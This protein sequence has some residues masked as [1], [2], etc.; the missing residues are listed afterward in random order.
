M[1]QIG[2]VLHYRLAPSIRKRFRWTRGDGFNHEMVD[3]K[4]TKPYSIHFTERGFPVW[5]RGAMSSW[6]LIPWALFSVFQYLVSWASWDEKTRFL[7]FYENYGEH[8]CVE[9]KK[10]GIVSHI[11]PFCSDEIY[12]LKY[13]FRNIQIHQKLDN[14]VMKQKISLWMSFYMIF[15]LN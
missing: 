3:L 1:L 9:G 7:L 14:G 2:T 8:K 13:L 5:C 4:E 15:F 12:E 6:P 10:H 11:F